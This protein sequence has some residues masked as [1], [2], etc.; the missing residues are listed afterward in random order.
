MKYTFHRD[1]AT[2]WFMEMVPKRKTNFILKEFLLGNND[3][4]FPFFVC[5]F[6]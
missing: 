1:L 2:D 3:V 5:V 4:F 6:L